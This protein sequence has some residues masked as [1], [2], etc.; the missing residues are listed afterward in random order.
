MATLRELWEEWLRLDMRPKTRV[1]IQ[2]LVERGDTEELERRLRPRISF[3]TAGLRARMQAGFARMNHLVV[4]QTSQGLAE[5]LLKNVPDAKDCGIVIGRDGRHDSHLFAEMAAAVFLAKRFRVWYFDKVVHTPMVPFTIDDVGAAAGIM[6]TA[7]HNP[8]W[9]NGYKVY[10]QNG[11]QINSPED[12]SIAAYILDNL[13][14]MENL[15]PIHNGH[16]THDR[17]LLVD[18]SIVFVPK[19]YARVSDLIFAEPYSLKLPSFVYTAMH[20]VGLPF[21]H[22]SLKRIVVCDARSKHMKQSDV[23]HEIMYIVESQAMPDP[24]FSTVQYP[25]PEEEGALDL[26]KEMATN[27][28]ISLIFA[29][30]PD[31]DRFAVAERVEG[32]WHQFTGDQVGVLLGYYMSTFNSHL[33]GMMM[34]TSAVSSQMLAKIGEVEGFTV[35]ETLTGF[36]W[37][38]NRS[39]ELG[40]KVIYAYE[41]ALG[42]MLPVIVH[43]K[44]GVAA[45]I[46]FLEACARWQSPWSKL[47]K[48]YEKYGYF[49]T[50]NTYWRCDDHEVV[51]SVFAKIRQDVS[52]LSTDRKL[53]R[54]RDLTCGTD[55]GTEDNKPILPSD[56]NTQ[57]ITCWLS[58]NEYDDGIR[59][60]I[61]A[62]GTEPKV[63]LYLEC[64][65]RSQANARIG[66][67]EMLKIINATWFGD[68]RLV[69]EKKYDLS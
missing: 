18:A 43:D 22:E 23:V 39:M 63:K 66:A 16:S 69:L 45:A 57:M 49:E 4:I 38:G 24:D 8:G 67:S 19:Y 33:K 3:G 1:E 27:E 64:Q 7:S 41:E 2:K 9:D 28:G 53:E 44:D 12:K 56:P 21:I 46:L 25:N 52:D 50:R 58:G 34:L 13:E 32:E 59:F 26:A 11:C 29:N 6:I 5:Y 51:D 36:K 55:S 37:L 65:S 14:P 35:E 31:A 40:D 47:Q 20:G 30:D 61:R 15:E 17:A 54:L 62:S 10:G 42:Y 48:L 60:T 68:K